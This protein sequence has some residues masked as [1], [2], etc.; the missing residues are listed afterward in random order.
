M[1]LR[2]VLC[3]CLLPLTAATQVALELNK[4]ISARLESGKTDS[5]Q[6]F[7]DK[8]TYIE[9]LADQVDIDV[10]LFLIGPEGNRL[11]QLNFLGIGGTELLIYLADA[12]G[13]YRVEVRA[14]DQGS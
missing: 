14:A 12:D 6:V 5:H 2:V 9:L 4:P 1:L 10:E 13:V 3:A 11:Q 8:G 7:L